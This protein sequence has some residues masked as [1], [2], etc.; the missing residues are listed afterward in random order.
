M[1]AVFLSGFIIPINFLPDWAQPVV[2]WLPFSAMVQTPVEIYLGQ[3]VGLDM[4]LAYVHQ[5]S[6]AVVVWLAGR[7]C[8]ALAVRRVVVHGG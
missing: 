6:W 7:L 4:G 8:L 1:L 3:R 5:A 2:R